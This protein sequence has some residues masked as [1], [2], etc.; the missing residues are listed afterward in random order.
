MFPPVSNGPIPWYVVFREDPYEP[1]A[2]KVRQK[3]PEISI[4]PWMTLAD[5]T[6][7]ATTSYTPAKKYYIHNFLFSEYNF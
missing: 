2:Q 7:R 6:L 1:M 4:G 5:P 3:L